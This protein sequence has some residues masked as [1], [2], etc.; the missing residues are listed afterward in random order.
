[1]NLL[2]LAAAICALG[3]PANNDTVLLDFGADWC[4]YCRQMEPVVGQL[5]AQGFPVRKVNVDKDHCA[6]GEI[7]RARVAVLCDVGGRQG[8]GSSGGGH[9]SRA[10]GG[11]VSS[12]RR[13]AGNDGRGARQAPRLPTDEV[14]AIP[15]PAT[16]QA[17][18]DRDGRPETEI[19]S[20][21]RRRKDELD[22]AASANDSPFDQ[23]IRASVRLR[24]EDHSGVSCGSGTIIDSRQGEALILTCG[25]MFREADKDSRIMVDLFGPGA[26]QAVPGRLIDYDL[27]SEVGLLSIE[28]DFPVTV[29]HLAPAGYAIRKGDHVISVGCDGGEDATAKETVIKSINRYGGPANLQIG[30]QPVQGRSGGGLFTPEGLVIGVCNAGDPEDNEGEFSHLSVVEEMLDRNGLAFAYQ[31]A[32][33][34]RSGWRQTAGGWQ[35]AGTLTPALSQG[36]RENGVRQLQP[37]AVREPAAVDGGGQRLTA[38]EQA[39]LEACA[40]RRKGRR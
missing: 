18:P 26:P 34:G 8:S 23:L 2:H 11:D 14:A 16:D 35:N 20:V 29:A 5:A 38:N 30:F 27:K 12:Q 13:R 19:V 17:G 31:D 9:R 6:G 1:M 21:D 39:S 33:A 10:A 7:R 25:H 40:T 3:A 4:G 22:A 15:F 24:I 37:V 36:E 32:G 28:V